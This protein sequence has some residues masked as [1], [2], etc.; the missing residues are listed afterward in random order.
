MGEA[1]LNNV[2]LG[3]GDPKSDAVENEEAE[4]LPVG[5]SLV[6]GS[7]VRE[8]LRGGSDGMVEA[9]PDSVTL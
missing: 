8:A 7:A 2:L 9:E 1:E 6:L 4:R 5:S 3:D